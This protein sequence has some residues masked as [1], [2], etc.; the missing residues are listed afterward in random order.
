[1]DKSHQRDNWGKRPLPVS[2]LRYAQMDTH[3][4]PLLRDEFHK[5]LLEQ[6]RMQEAQETFAELCRLP[7]A[8]VREFDPT[9]FWKLG[10]PNHLNRRQLKILRELDELRENIA[11]G[12]NVPPFRVFSN[13]V[14]VHIARQGPSSIPE[15]KRVHG[16]SA[17]QVRRY[18]KRILKAVN[19]GK[20]AEGLP[21]APRHEPPPP[22]ITDRYSA[23]HTWRKERAQMRGVES[24]VIVSKQTLWDIA[25]K[26]PTALDDMADIPGM[27]PWRLNAYGAE[28]LEVL[29]EME[30]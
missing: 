10:L 21:R 27:G 28:I 4:L 16:L 12:R 2:S 7:P 15:L 3:Y 22:E 8:T 17:R 1:M 19:R 14:M 29:Q 24:D 11:E 26:A 6:D 30:G 25:H 18:G 13:N 9:G 23:L 20:S 5:L